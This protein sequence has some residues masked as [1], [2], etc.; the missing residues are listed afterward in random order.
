M[1]RTEPPLAPTQPVS[2]D[3]TPPRL[4]AADTEDDPAADGPELPADQIMT[5]ASRTLCN[6]WTLSYG[7]TRNDKQTQEQ[8]KRRWLI[9][10]KL[11]IHQR[12][13][14]SRTQTAPRIH[15]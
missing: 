15:S 4:P 12:S 13:Q 1:S 9:C 5:L 2:P 10:G 6:H 7:M 11:T 8:L 3:R 14:T